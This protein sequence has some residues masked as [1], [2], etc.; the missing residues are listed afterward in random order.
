MNEA[1]AAAERQGRA[2]EV[3][4]TA[5]RQRTLIEVFGSTERADETVRASESVKASS[6]SCERGFM[7]TTTHGLG[8]LRQ[9]NDWVKNPELGTMKACTRALQELE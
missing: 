6:K 1:I 5:E 4:E 2:L 7:V 9:K 3:F 8:A